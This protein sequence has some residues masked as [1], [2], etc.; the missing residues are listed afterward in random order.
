MSVVGLRLCDI[1]LGDFSHTLLR[2]WLKC[3]VWYVEAKIRILHNLFSF[4]CDWANGS[5]YWNPQKRQIGAG[6]FALHMA[7]LTR[8]TPIFHVGDPPG[9]VCLLS[10]YANV[11][12]HV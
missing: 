8:L 11:T 1:T 7:S 2:V 3:N 12:D 10:I 6:V 5:L 9:I 4:S